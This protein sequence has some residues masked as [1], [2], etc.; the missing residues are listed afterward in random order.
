MNINV[1]Y[2][3]KKDYQETLVIQERLLLM[4]Q[5]EKIIDTLILVEHPPVL[6]LGRRGEHTNIV[7]S[8]EVLEK[9]GI[10]I[11]EVNRGGDVTYHGPGQLVGYPIFDLNN[12]DRDIKSFVIR[13]EQV[14]ISLLKNEYDIEAY[15]KDKKYT[16][17]W[18]NEKKITA[19][20]IAVKRW[21][22]MHGFAFNVNT[23]LEHYHWI[24]PCGITDKGVTSLEKLLG[25]SLDLEKVNLQV[26]HH[27]CQVFD[28][29]AIFKDKE[30]IRQI[31]GGLE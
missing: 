11:Y 23:N 27:L 28:C 8:K 22:T 26:V 25:R 14:I 16:G 6:T 21:V 3:G 20:G 1:V 17:V 29:S 24:N 12:Y 19:I 13:I 9:Q 7:V 10:Y 4:R 15:I 2:L 30:W 31:T 18:V 5:Q